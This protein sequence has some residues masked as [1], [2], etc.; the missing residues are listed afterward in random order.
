VFMLLFSAIGWVAYKQAKNE[1]NIK[2]GR[3]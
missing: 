1:I 3:K 2:E